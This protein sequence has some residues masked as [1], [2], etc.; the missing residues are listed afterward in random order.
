ML[1]AAGLLLGACG[2]AQSAPTAAAYPYCAGPGRAG[3]AVSMTHFPAHSGG[4]R[5]AVTVDARDR[6]VRGVVTLAGGEGL[7]RLDPAPAG[8]VVVTVHWPGVRSQ[9][10]STTVD[11]CGAGH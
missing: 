10:V 8:P 9:Q 7:Y 1:P 2:A 11:A 3:L 5:V 4:D 6:T